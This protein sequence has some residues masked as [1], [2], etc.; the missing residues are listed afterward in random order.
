[1]PP[2]FLN[3]SNYFMPKEIWYEVYISDEEGTRTLMDFNSLEYAKKF[4][5]EYNLST[6]KDDL[7]IDEWEMVNDMPTK[8]KTIL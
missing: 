8:I 4:I 1:M 2:I 5:W 6:G 3:N 7:F